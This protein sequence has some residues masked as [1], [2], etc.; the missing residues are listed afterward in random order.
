MDIQHDSQARR[1]LAPLQ[2]GDAF[3]AYTEPDESTLDLQHT[4]V[5]PEAAG[6]GIGSA[7]VEHVFV[8][9]RER[10]KKIIPSCPFVRAWLER[11]PQYRE[12]IRTPA[13][14]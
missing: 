5:P 13:R 8:Y 4:V 10:G 11:H 9:V 7:L 12:Q 1:F 3:V 14:H 2:S 6:R